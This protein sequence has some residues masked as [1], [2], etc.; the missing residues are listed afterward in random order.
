MTMEKKFAMPELPY[1]LDSLEPMMSERQLTIHYSKHHAAYVKAANAILEKLQ[2][3]RSDDSDLDM[4]AELKSL[5]FNVAGHF[6]HSLF[7]ENLSPNAKGESVPFGKIEEM[8]IASFG[9]FERF[10]KE[11]T[12]AALS[13]EG[14]GWAV[15][16]YEKMTESLM[17]D[18]IEK[19]NVNLIPSGTI[20]LVVDVFEHAYYLD[21]QNDRAAYLDNFWKLVD[22]EAVSKR[23]HIV[24]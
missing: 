23:C 22:W 6:L 13:V 14:S 15:L 17:I 24:C 19:H 3:A 1:A 21:Y 2:K 4:K 12:Q 5:S 16:V 11:F 18:Q 20:I 8:I 9:S 7:W 10:K